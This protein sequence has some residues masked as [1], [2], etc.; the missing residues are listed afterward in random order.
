MKWVPDKTGRFARRPHYQPEAIDAQCDRFVQKF[1]TKKYGKIEFPIKTE[2]LTILIEERA[3][4]DSCVDLSHEDGDVDGVTEF[5]LGLRPLVSISDRLS[6]PNME[7]RLRT[8]LTHEFGHVY[9]HQFMFETMGQTAPLFPQQTG[10]HTNKCKRANIDRAPESD[11]M[12]WQAGYACG[13]ILIPSTALI[14]K[15]QDFRSKHRL[16]FR[17]LAVDSDAGQELIALVSSTFKTS[18][19]ATRVRL[20]KKG[21]LAGPGTMTSDL[22]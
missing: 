18:R 14:E 9:F 10:G 12:E 13:A 4:L 15:V 8:T 6:A 19:D 17:N 1:L 3:D 22:F 2:D 5:R 21:I 20:L 16:P 7:N 11:W